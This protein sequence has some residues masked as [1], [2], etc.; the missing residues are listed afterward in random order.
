MRIKRTLQPYI[1]KDKIKFGF[2]NVSLVREIDFNEENINL[3]KKLDNDID[4]KLLSN[5]EKQV[6]ESMILWD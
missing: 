4:I 5:G 1:F 2:G 6:V 3:I